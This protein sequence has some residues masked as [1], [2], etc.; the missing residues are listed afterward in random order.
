MKQ[1]YVSRENY[2]TKYDHHAQM[3]P[4]HSHPTILLWFIK[5][6]I[7]NPLNSVQ[8]I[9]SLALVSSKMLPSTLLENINANTHDFPIGS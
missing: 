7:S 5:T 2:T 9:D 8:A 6:S 4:A 1:V 3:D